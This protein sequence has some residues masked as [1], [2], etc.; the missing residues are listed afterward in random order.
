MFW[1]LVT[2]NMIEDNDDYKMV[3]GTDL[4][5]TQYVFSENILV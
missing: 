3:K 2:L 4:K 5:S 1:T